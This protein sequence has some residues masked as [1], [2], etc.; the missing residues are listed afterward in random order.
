MNSAGE[1]VER[2][3]LGRPYRPPWW[4]II[5]GQVLAIPVLGWALTATVGVRQVGTQMYQQ[6]SAMARTPAY[7]DASTKPEGTVFLAVSAPFVVRVDYS[8]YTAKRRESG[9]RYY[10]W[11]P[12]GPITLVR[13]ER[14]AWR[15][16]GAE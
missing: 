11:L 2:L 13:H 7:N 12:T 5:L 8:F 15:T 6:F 16:H 3:A 14:R 4:W 9:R 10:L 1:P